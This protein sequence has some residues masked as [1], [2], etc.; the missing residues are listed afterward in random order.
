[1]SIA[2]FSFG[3][4]SASSLADLNLFDYLGILL[5]ALGSWMNTSEHTRY[6]FKKDENNKGKLYTDGLF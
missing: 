4:E 6:L 3:R 1:M 5:F 2:L